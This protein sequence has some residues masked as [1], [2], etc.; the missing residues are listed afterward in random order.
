ML[1]YSLGLMAASLGKLIKHPDMNVSSNV[2]SPQLINAVTRL[3][4]VIKL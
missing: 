2:L 3:E 4:G 1:L